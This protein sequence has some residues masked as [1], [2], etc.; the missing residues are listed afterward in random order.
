V[1]LGG[2]GAKSSISFDVN[3]AP[4]SGTFEINPKNGYEL[5]TKFTLE[6]RGWVDTDTPL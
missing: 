4:T 2:A 6:G 5:E 1:T 3:E